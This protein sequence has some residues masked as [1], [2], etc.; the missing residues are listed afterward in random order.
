M[1][2]R[3]KTGNRLAQ[4]PEGA[5]EALGDAR[6]LANG[7]RCET[8][9]YLRPGESGRRAYLA[10]RYDCELFAV[11]DDDEVGQTNEVLDI[12]NELIALYHS[13]KDLP[14]SS[15]LTVVGVQ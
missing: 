6:P 2:V 11:P 14:T 13:S 12:V 1:F 15:L 7:Y 10:V 4:I 8:L 9:F 3:V 5:C